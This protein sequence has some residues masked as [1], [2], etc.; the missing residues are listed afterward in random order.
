V[1]HTLV[2][3]D[4]IARRALGHHWQGLSRL[5]AEEFVRLVGN[6]LD[7]LGVA[8]MDGYT[9]EKV[10]FPRREIDGARAR[11]RSRVVTTREIVNAM[12]YR[13]IERGGRWAVYESRG[14]TRVSW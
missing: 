6:T 14:I 13:L 1:T 12:A 2:D 3:A 10:T 7:R 8:G 5:E 4:Q 11:V 9:N